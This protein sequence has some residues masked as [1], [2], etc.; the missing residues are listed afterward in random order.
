MRQTARLYRCSTP[1]T[2]PRN[3]HQRFPHQT[4]D[5]RFSVADTSALQ[6]GQVFTEQ[7]R[8]ALAP[9]EYEVS[10][11]V[12]GG[13]ASSAVEARLDMS[14]PDYATATGVTIS[15]VQLAR[16]IARAWRKR[17]RKSAR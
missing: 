17:S 8:T 5:F 6:A 7:V 4:L 15:S 10:A 11:G 3:F 16:R 14:V 9:G 1:V 12:A 13:D 2:G